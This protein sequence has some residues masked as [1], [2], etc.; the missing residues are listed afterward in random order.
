MLDDS[1]P[2]GDLHSSQNNP[3]P[4]RPK[5]AG[6]SRSTEESG[7]GNAAANEGASHGAGREERLPRQGIARTALAFAA[8]LAAA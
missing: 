5:T 2:L 3:P 8:A 1:L 7:R 4:A 6:R